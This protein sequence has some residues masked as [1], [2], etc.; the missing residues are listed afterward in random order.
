MTVLKPAAE[1]TGTTAH[2][3]AAV[4]PGN[5]MPLVSRLPFICLLLLCVEPKSSIF[6]LRMSLG[7]FRKE[8]RIRAAAGP[9]G[10]EALA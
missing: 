2:S 9:A 5:D 8:R 7:V 6:G 4:A 1:S 10:C 3:N